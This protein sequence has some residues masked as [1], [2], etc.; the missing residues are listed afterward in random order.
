MKNNDLVKIDFFYNRVKYSALVRKFS[1]TVVI[2]PN[3]AVLKTNCMV[4]TAGKRRSPDKIH[5]RNIFDPL[6]DPLP[7][8]LIR[9]PGDWDKPLETR[10][11]VTFAEEV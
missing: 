1:S 3:K 9:R 11:P 2:L 7:L 8:E 5:T 6:G 10:L 4:H